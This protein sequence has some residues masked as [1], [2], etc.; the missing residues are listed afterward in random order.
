MSQDLTPVVNPSTGESGTRATITTTTSGLNTSVLSSQYK[1]ARKL[2]EGET[3]WWVPL[4]RPIYRRLPAVSEAYQVNFYADGEIGYCLIPP[5]RG[6]FGAGSLNVTTNEEKTVLLIY[7]GVIVWETGDTPILKTVVDLDQIGLTSGRWLVA[8]QRIYSDAPQ[9]FEYAVTDYSLAGADIAIGDSA[10]AAY[11]I[12]YEPNGN[13]WPYPGQFA[14]LNQNPDLNWVNYTQTENSNPISAV[15]GVTPGFPDWAQPVNGWLE[16]F[17][18]E[19]EGTYLPWKLDEIVMRT[20]LKFANPP[21]ASLY[22][23]TGDETTPWGFVQEQSAKLDS[24]GYYWEFQTD[25]TPQVGWRV[26]WPDP[27]ISVS[28]VEVSGQITLLRKPSVPVTRSQLAIYPENRVPKDAI[29]CRLAIIDVV[30]S[31]LVDKDD[32]RN[33]ATR[34]FEPIADWLTAFAD[35]MLIDNY[36]K[37]KAYAPEFMSPPT[38]LKSAY[39]DL[40]EYGILVSDEEPPCPPTPPIPSDPPVLTEA[41]VSVFP[42]DLVATLT[43]V[44]VFVT[45]PPGTVTI[46]GIKL[47]PLP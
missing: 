41:R 34:D 30:D 4:G 29:L 6:Q 16:W 24:N 21:T 39:F 23:Y 45:P 31:R 2:V 46:N 47:R 37:V 36:A 40:E 10:S 27:K 38:L 8:Y 15:N 28:S 35:E 19:F 14:F 1:K 18:T 33:I 5:G 13:P 3:E 44:S 32:I 7:D 20:P 22:F 26:E 12:A 17:T 43:R 42:P 25:A 11:A 9:P